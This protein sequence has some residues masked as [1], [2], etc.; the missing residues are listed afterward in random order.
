[1]DGCNAQIG[2]DHMLWHPVV[3]IGEYLG[4][5]IIPFFWCPVI[6]IFYPVVLINKIIFS[7]QTAQFIPILQI[8]ISPFDR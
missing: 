8:F 1:M 7:H 4:N 6:K 2:G 3:N 5:G